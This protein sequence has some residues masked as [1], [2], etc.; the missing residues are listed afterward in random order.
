M[1]NAY[2]KVLIKCLNNMTKLCKTISVLSRML[3]L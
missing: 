2:Y 3:V 1:K